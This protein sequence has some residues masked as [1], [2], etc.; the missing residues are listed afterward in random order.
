[1]EPYTLF[2]R[3][4]RNEDSFVTSVDILNFLR[5]NGIHNITEADCY[6][7]VKFFDSDED[8]RLN[9][10]DF[11]QMV[12]PCDNP[13]LRAA[14]T[15]RPNQY[16]SQFDYLTLDVERDLTKLIMSEIELHRKSEKLKQQL[17]SA[18]D[19]SEDAVY[20]TVDDWGYGYVDTRNIKGFFRNNKYKATDEDCIS[21]IRRL[22]LDA[23]SK[24]TREEFL[25]GLRPQEPYSKMI[26][27]EQMAKKEELIRIKR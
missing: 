1:M 27:R 13:Q 25:A 17:E 24:L 10:P 23:D 20:G 19:Y 11:M 12:L 5:D 22:D 6:Y 3:L 4:D 21:I 15:Q 8:G 16:I 9:Y 14:A 7:L 26:V 2:Q 18:L